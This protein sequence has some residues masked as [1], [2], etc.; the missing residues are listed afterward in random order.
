MV[1]RREASY[2][3]PFAWWGPTWEAP[4]ARSVLDLISGGGAGAADGGVA[5]G[6]AGAA[7]F[8]ACGGGA[9]WGGQNDA[10]DRAA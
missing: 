9:E 2:D 10:A 7:G 1:G 4:V 8:D 6:V 3:E 5:L